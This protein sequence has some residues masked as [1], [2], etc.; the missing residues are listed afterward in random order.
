MNNT[1]IPQLDWEDLLSRIKNNNVIPVIG[2]QLYRV[3]I[4]S[5]GKKNFPLYEYLAD[6]VSKGKHHKFPMAC[7]KFISENNDSRRKLSDFLKKQ[8]QDICLTEENP[9]YK[10]ARIKSFDLF[11]NTTCDNFLLKALKKVRTSSPH[12]FFY[13]TKQKYIDPKMPVINDSLIFHIFGNL[14]VKENLYIAYTEGFMVD[15]IM[16]FF[17][18]IEKSPNLRLIQRMVDSALLFLGC[19]YDDWLLQYLM[20]LLSCNSYKN[21]NFKLIMGDNFN[22]PSND[23]F[24]QLIQFLIKQNV[25]EFYP[26]KDDNFV[27]LLF[28]E[29]QT[30]E[31]IQPEDFPGKVFL[32]FEGRDRPVAQELTGVMQDAGIGVWLDEFNLELGKPVKEEIVDAINKCT[33]FIPLTSKHTKKKVDKKKDPKYHIKE[34]EYAHSKHITDKKKLNDDKKCIK[35]IPIVLDSV[36]NIY[37]E[38]KDFYCYMLPKKETDRKYDEFIKKLKEILR[39]HHE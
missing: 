14:M 12:T 33:V 37:D 4:D 18:N 17:K 21:E 30:E 15:T 27:D 13:T 24:Q 11:V 6:V 25:V 20:C 36:E 23:L 29:I 38:F 22:N 34:W 16:S 32:S 3:D 39:E 26:V 7:Q 19:E 35:I 10:L 9:L 1:D 2:R 5:D 31:I 8:L 28:D